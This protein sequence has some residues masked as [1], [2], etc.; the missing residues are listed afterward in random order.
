MKAARI[1]AG[2]LMVV[3]GSGVAWAQPELRAWTDVEGRRIE[4]RWIATEGEA[5]R[6]RRADGQEFSVPLGR[7]S[8]ADR[9]YAREQAERGAEAPGGVTPAALNAAFGVAVWGEGSLT[10]ENPTAIAARLR[11]PVESDTADFESFRAYGDGSEKVLGAGVY[12]VAVRGAENA[13][14]E[15]TVMFANRGDSVPKTGD[16]RS[17]L[18]VLA[19]AMRADQVAVTERLDALLGPSRSEFLP[20][21]VA[22][23][24][25]VRRWDWRDLAL[26]LAY[27]KDQY[28][29]LRIVP[30]DAGRTVFLADAEVR[31][32]LAER[33]TRRE[34]GDVILDRLPMVDQGPKGYCLPATFERYLRY[35]G[36]P[37]DMYVLALAAQTGLSGGTYFRDIAQVVD[38]LASRHSRSLKAVPLKMTIPQLARHLDA[39]FPIVWGMTSTAEFNEATNAHTRARAA[40]A[41]AWAVW[42]A[43]QKARRPAELRRDPTRGHACLIVGYNRA[44]GEIAVSDSWGPD[45]RE[46]W[47]R[48]EAAAGV[49]LDEFWIISS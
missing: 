13:F 31:R 10:A 48:I 27:P 30:A 25:T 18:R 26:R 43:E 23:G 34:N 19:E 39:G 17:R 28:V 41:A 11:L 32:R 8:E 42:E 40:A 24:E 22:G 44:T 33:V 14:E 38:R 3:M 46:R 5:V 4:A 9:A 7:L 1:A 36:I 37:A 35:V 47:I 16:E 29:A 2:C 6:I 15:L 20:G 45:Y 49:S 12:T 21:G